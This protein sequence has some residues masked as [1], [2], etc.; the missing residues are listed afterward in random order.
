MLS[1]DP[2]IIFLIEKSNIKPFTR[3]TFI[4]F[5]HKMICLLKKSCLTW[6]FKSSL[7][8]LP[9]FSFLNLYLIFDL[10]FFLSNLAK[11][12][13]YTNQRCMLN[14]KCNLIFVYMFFYGFEGSFHVTIIFLSWIR[15]LWIQY[16][17]IYL[18]K[19]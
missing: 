16:V 7:Y 8:C 18:K 17:K 19:I 10:V 12:S 11:T 2:I 9:L 15:S 3:S 6:A 14:C 4:K 1:K 5:G 13:K